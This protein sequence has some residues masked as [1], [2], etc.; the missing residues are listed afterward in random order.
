MKFAELGLPLDQVTH[1]FVVVT[2]HTVLVIVKLDFRV[3]LEALI[4]N[5]LIDTV[6]A[7]IGV[8]ARRRVTIVTPL[9]VF[10]IVITVLIGVLVNGSIS[11]CLFYPLRNKLLVL[12]L[13]KIE[14]FLP[15]FGHQELDFLLMVAEVE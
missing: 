4:G 11:R 6:E 2:A 9:V 3:I 1:D 7:K 10:I 12:L 5:G 14:S 15:L 8:I 13:L